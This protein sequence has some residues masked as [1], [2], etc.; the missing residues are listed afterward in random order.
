MS[1]ITVTN[2]SKL[3]R[4]RR[5]RLTIREHLQESVIQK[6]IPNAFLA[7]KGITFSVGERESVA[8]IGANGA[9]K[10]T[11]LSL[12][13]GLAHPDEG[14]VAINTTIAPL[15]EL[16]AGFHYDLTGREN[17]YMN[18]ALLGMTRPQVDARFQSIV[19]FSELGGAILEP[20]RVYSSGMVMRLG[21]SIAVHC[22]ASLFVIDEVLGVGDASFYQKCLSKIRELRANWKVATLRFT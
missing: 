6:S 21:F 13:C 5:Q 16:G 2:A 4:R 19:E 8:I 17:V 3:F 22:D 1:L 18:A 7:L 20:V 14:S 11:L 12:V 10:S 15:L 9:G